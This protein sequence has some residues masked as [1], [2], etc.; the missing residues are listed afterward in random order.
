MD[1]AP[2]KLATALAG[3]V[4]T[5]EIDIEVPVGDD[6]P[7]VVRCEEGRVSRVAHAEPGRRVILRLTAE[8]AA[9]VAAGTANAQQLLAEGALKIG[10]RIDVL[11][12]QAGALAEMRRD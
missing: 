1:E 11:Q 10:G 9:R 6:P 7:Y 8:G 12:E 4:T 2:E 3:L 5:A